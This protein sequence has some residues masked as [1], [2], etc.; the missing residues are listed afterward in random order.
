MS[1]SSYQLR[2]SPVVG[3]AV[4]VPTVAAAEEAEVPTVAVETVV[5]PTVAVETV[6]MPTVAVETVVMPTVAVAIVAMPTVAVAITAMSTTV[7]GMAIAIVM[8]VVVTGIV[9]TDGA[10]PAHGGYLDSARLRSSELVQPI[11][12]V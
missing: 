8:R 1:P 7:I 11:A 4:A 6:V 12:N 5:M 9:A 10:I 2:M 3:A